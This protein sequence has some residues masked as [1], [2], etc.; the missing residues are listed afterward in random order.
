MKSLLNSRLA[1]CRA[2]HPP[3]PS[4]SLKKIIILP[5]ESSSYAATTPFLQ[6]QQQQQQR[7]RSV[8]RQPYREKA[9]ANEKAYGHLP[10]SRALLKSKTTSDFN[11]TR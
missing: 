2:M 6:Q 10:I 9:E 7:A 1:S 4:S 5:E 3:C 8:Y 11:T